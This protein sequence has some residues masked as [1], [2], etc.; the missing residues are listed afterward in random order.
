MS[1][2]AQGTPQN[3]FPVTSVPSS[4]NGMD[5]NS[6]VFTTGI[7]SLPTSSVHSAPGTGYVTPLVN[8]EAHSMEQP[9]FDSD[10]SENSTTLEMVTLSVLEGSVWRLFALGTLPNSL[11]Q[12]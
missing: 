11:L 2:M 1:P 4:Q 9:S 12:Y 3:L 5:H 7:S 10:V 8:S 6:D